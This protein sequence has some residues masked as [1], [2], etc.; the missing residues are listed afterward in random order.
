[1]PPN[2]SYSDIRADDLR[3]VTRGRRSFWFSILLMAALA[4]LTGVAVFMGWIASLEPLIPEQFWSALQMALAATPAVIWLAVFAL[5]TYKKE[6]LR[7]TTFLLWL[8]TALLYLVTV[9]PL[10][11]HVFEINDWL[12]VFWWSELAGRFLV[13]APLEMFLIYLVLRYGV[14]PAAV[15]QTRTDGAIF[16][17]AAALGVATMVNLAATHAPGFADLGQGLLFVSEMAL[18]YAA[19]GAWL[20]YLLSQVRF[21]RTNIFYLA[22]GLFLA[23]IFHALFFFLLSFINARNDFLPSLDGL[24]FS[25]LFALLSF[26]LLYWRIRQGN[27]AFMHMASLV[28][29]KNEAASPR[30]MLEDV[31]QLVE[32]N[33]LEVRPSPP[34]PPS[35]NSYEAGDDADELEN[36]KQSWESLIAEQEADDDAV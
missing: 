25:G 23:I 1:M 34:P 6:A 16:G 26:L 32:S 9:A 5:L 24:I 20:G 36:L 30:S 22:A 19:L 33:Q 35:L 18:G 12:G 31:V 7:R 27:K 28:E 17:V 4:I 15:F 21:K 3:N 11:A 14:Y 10:L 13:V 29:I 2:V 8:V